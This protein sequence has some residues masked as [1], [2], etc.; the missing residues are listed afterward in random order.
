MNSITVPR[1]PGES[2]GAICKL[3]KKDGNCLTINVEYN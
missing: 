1:L 2:V 3:S